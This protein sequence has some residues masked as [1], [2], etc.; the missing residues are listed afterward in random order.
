MADHICK[1]I[2]LLQGE[3]TE[4]DGGQVYFADWILQ[5]ESKLLVHVKRLVEAHFHGIYS[6][7]QKFLR[8]NENCQYFYCKRRGRKGCGLKKSGS[9]GHFRQAIIQLSQNRNAVLTS[10][11]WVGF[12]WQSSF[13]R[14]IHHIVRLKC[15]PASISAGHQMIDKTT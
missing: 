10:S 6:E 14:H 7:T 4:V 3:K 15:T 11:P 12:V 13:L 5:V 9:K 1:C 2:D 8:T